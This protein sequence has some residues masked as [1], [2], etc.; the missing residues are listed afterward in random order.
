MIGGTRLSI[1][2]ERLKSGV[3][4]LDELLGGLILGDNV[5][6]V[7]DG[8][9]V[10]ARLEDAMLREG[11]RRGQRCLYVTVSTAPERLRERLPSAV[12]VLDARARGALGQAAALEMA[13]LEGAGGTPPGCVVVDSLD[14][15][16]RRWGADRAVTF[17]SRVC[18]QLFDLGALAYWRG[19]RRELGSAVIE[20]ITQ[21]TQCVLE[22][23]DD[24]LR[25]IKAE[26]RLASVQG[27]LLRLQVTNGGLQI[28]DERALGRLGRGL[29]RLRE[30]RNLTQ[31]DLARLLE[32]SPSAISQAEGGR[33]GLSL[34]TVILLSER[35]GVSLDQLLSTSPESGYVLARRPRSPTPGITALLDDPKAGLRAYLV[36]L[37]PSESGAPDIVHKGPELVLV[38]SGLVQVTIGSDTP[39]M[40]AGDAALATRAAVSG[41]RNL[42]SEPASLFWVVRD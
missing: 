21:V 14:R 24:H 27:R 30:E 13:I 26:G 9:D 16:A 17:F 12:K 29:E 10:V 41:W 39:V 36:R 7:L 20:R 25:V 31:S 35:L 32:V 4:E 11:L 2:S 19:S 8:P 15:L 1:G 40:R 18:P 28:S 5:V 34:D 22:V 38:A 3:P 42:T 33:R 23:A 6:W 37:G